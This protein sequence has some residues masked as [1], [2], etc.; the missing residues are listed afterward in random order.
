MTSK[1]ID[2]SALMNV[3]GNVYNNPKLFEAEDKYFF[4]EE[5]FVDDFHKI[6]FGTILNLHELGAAEITLNTITDYLSTR[7]KKKAIFDTNKGNEYILKCAENAN[8][9]T[10][11]YYYWQCLSSPAEA[12]NRLLCRQRAILSVSST[13]HS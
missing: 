1:Y 9:S 13:P 5:D 6:V 4:S 2:I 11:N 7:P 8:I 10:F 3:I 12:V